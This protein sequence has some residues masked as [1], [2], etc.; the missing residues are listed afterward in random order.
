MEARRWIAALAVTCAISALWPA[1]PVRS[2]DWPTYGRTVHRSN[3]TLDHISPGLI[4]RWSRPVPGPLTA[5]PVIA[6][7][8]IL[9]GSADGTL[10][11]FGIDGA[12]AWKFSALSRIQASAAV[13][14]NTAYVT[15]YDGNLY[16]LDLHTGW[17]RWQFATASWI[18]ATPTVHSGLV[19]TACYAGLVY[20]VEP[21]SGSLIWRF[22]VGDDFVDQAP[23]ISGQGLIIVTVKGSVVRVDLASG[24]RTWTAAVSGRPCAPPLAAGDSVFVVSR[25]TGEQ[26]GAISAFNATTGES[27]W[28]VSGTDSDWSAPAHSAGSLFLARERTLFMLDAATGD[29]QK[30]FDIE[31]VAVGPPAIARDRVFLPVVSPETGSIHSIDVASGSS[32]TVGLE[33]RPSTPL[34]LSDGNLCL[35]TVERRVHLLA[36]LRVVVGVTDL[37]FRGVWPFMKRGQIIVPLRQ[38]MEAVG[39]HVLWYHGSRT[40][41]VRLGEHTVSVQAG[42]GE[43]HP[44]WL[45]EG[46]LV[47]PLRALAEQLGVTVRWDPTL[48]AVTLY[49]PLEQKG[50]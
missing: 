10:H 6:G 20:A 26:Q 34:A 47:G 40:A 27:R 35:G 46:R 4:A 8:K 12:P 31:G 48:S 19:I 33:G 2:G 9:I 36:P 16:A 45:I 11:A 44:V 29:E 49:P 39:A 38:V 14:D 18:V 30:R 7:G 15:S 1:P 22:S 5:G 28:T 24:R 17:L 41:T 37:P 25:R 43:D 21:L 50:E 42:T 23:T 3:H 13:V 32:W